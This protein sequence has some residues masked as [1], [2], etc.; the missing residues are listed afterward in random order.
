MYCAIV[1][2]ELGILAW[3]HGRN[4]SRR[5]LVVGMRLVAASCAMGVAWLTIKLVEVA[6]E[7]AGLLGTGNVLY[8][9][10]QVVLAVAILTLTVGLLIPPWPAVSAA[11]CVVDATPA[12]PGRSPRCGRT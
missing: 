8:A 7:Q 1:V 9:L 4:A 12:W 11:W 3:H 5:A 2:V 6:H 10:D